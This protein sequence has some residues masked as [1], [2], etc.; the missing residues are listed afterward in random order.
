MHFTRH[1]SRVTRHTSH[2][3]RHTSHVTRHTSHVT[4]HTSHV[5]R[6]TSHVTRH[7]SHVTHVRRRWPA[8]QFRGSEL[9]EQKVDVFHAP[10]EEGAVNGWVLG[11]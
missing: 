2:V 1:A 11:V 8:Q 6:H 7:T 3:T 9:E 10:E 5:T 4:R